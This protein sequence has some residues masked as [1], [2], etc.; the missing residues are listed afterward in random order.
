M[1]LKSDLKSLGWSQAELARRLGVRP[2]T[3][4][5]WGDVAPVYAAAYVELALELGAVRERVTAALR[6]TG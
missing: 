2:A 3:V 4:T 1:G 5:D 6:R